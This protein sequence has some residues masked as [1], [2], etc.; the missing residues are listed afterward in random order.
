MCSLRCDR[1]L[2]G[3]ASSCKHEEE[4]I[5]TSVD[6]D[7]AVLVKCLSD[8][9]AVVGKQICIPFAESLKKARRPFNIAEE[10]G[11]RSRG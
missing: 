11:D 10:E 6:L 4:G 7:S 8:D 9:P 1:S 2:D 5:P 3:F